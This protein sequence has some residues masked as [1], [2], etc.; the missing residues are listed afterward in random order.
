[1]ETDGLEPPHEKGRNHGENDDS[2]KTT[3]GAAQNPA[4]SV[5][6]VPAELV[7]LWE[8]LD[9]SARADLIAVARGLASVALSR[10]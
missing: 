10:R 3:A 9:T 5:S 2:Q 8:L 7:E 4:H 6:P 1:M